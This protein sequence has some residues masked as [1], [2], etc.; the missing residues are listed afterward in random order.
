[1]FM[2]A[3]LGNPTLRFEG[4]RHNAG[5]EVIDKITKKYDIPMKSRQG[6]AIIG[7][8]IIEGNKVLFVK[9]QTYM[10]LSGESIRTLTDYYG[11]DPVSELLVIVDDINLPLG[12]L[13]IRK[14]GSAGGHNGL[15]NIIFELDT[16]EF[17]RIR[18]GVGGKPEEY[19]MV[20]YVLS[21]FSKEEKKAM[22][23]A[24]ENAADAAVMICTGKMEAAMNRYNT[25]QQNT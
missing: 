2:I 14:S 10:N 20:D 8:G 16:E 11:I 24:Y 19:D 1:M 18:I 12:N 21:H 23:E 3:G 13:R 5:F 6:K 4:T 17:S 25:K 15:K 22:Q 9:P 7:K